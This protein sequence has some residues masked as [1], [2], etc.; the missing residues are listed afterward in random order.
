MKQSD[1]SANRNA[2]ALTLGI[3]S[4]VIGAGALL[5]GWVPF[6]G[7]LVIPFALIGG[8]LAVVGVVIGASVGRDWGLAVLGG[9]LCA[10]S[11]IVPIATTMLAASALGQLSTNAP[12]EVR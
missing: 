8:L 7:W 4:T 11:L 5:V 10:L 3:I 2:P 12:V 9:G 6:F 1:S